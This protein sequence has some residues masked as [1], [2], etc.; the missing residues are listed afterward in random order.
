MSNNTLQ[1]FLT[2]NSFH[3]VST[4]MRHHQQLTSTL[5]CFNTSQPPN[6]F[7]TPSHSPLAPCQCANVVLLHAWHTP[8]APHLSTPSPSPHPSFC[9]VSNNF[10]I[11]LYKKKT[12]HDLLNQQSMNSL[13]PHHLIPH[14]PQ[15]CTTR[16][17]KQ[18]LTPWR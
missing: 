6:T 17:I 9:G 3:P 14:K 10:S 4:L 7:A 8:Q 18:P 11:Y 5:E 16:H 1:N 15:W 13:N 2:K 12:K